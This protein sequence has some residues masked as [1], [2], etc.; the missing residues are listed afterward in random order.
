MINKVSKRNIYKDSEGNSWTSLVVE[1]KI[2]EA[3]RSKIDQ[4][5]DE[6]GYAFCE[7]CKRNDCKPIDCSHDISVKEAKESGRVE[8]SWDVSNITLRG[9][10]CH[11]IHD[12]NGINIGA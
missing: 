5:V 3:K 2:R 8:L 7:I 1:S 11:Q 9:R 4:F 6:N 12:K 10:R